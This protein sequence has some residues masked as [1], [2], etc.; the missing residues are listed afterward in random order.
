MPD[1]TQQPDR[2]ARELA[3]KLIHSE[4][5]DIFDFLKAVDLLARYISTGEMPVATA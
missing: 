2:E 4:V 5:L 1:M 3:V